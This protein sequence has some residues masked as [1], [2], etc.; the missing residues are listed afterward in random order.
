MPLP[1]F[2]PDLLPGGTSAGL[3]LTAVVDGIVHNGDTVTPSPTHDASVLLGFTG[4]PD[5]FSGGTGTVGAIASPEVQFQ[6]DYGS[7]VFND[8]LGKVEGVTAATAEAEPAS[9][10]AQIYD[11][12]C[13][14][15][16]PLRYR[17]RN[18][19]VSGGETY[20]SA[21]SGVITL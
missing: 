20:Q 9:D 14:F 2:L 15:N 8:I 1:G 12:G 13:P 5:T 3:L 19:A 10:L 21:W 17:A 7:G 16:I 6:A 18:V 11:M 4:D